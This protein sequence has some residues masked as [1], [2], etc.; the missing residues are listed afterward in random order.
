M[1]RLIKTSTDPKKSLLIVFIYLFILLTHE[2]AG[3]ALLSTKNVQHQF[4]A[5]F[6]RQ[7]I[8]IIH[9]AFQQ[10]SDKVAKVGRTHFCN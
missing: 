4:S 9:G 5:K 10:A 8:I 2:N 3:F 7:I 6:H 1:M